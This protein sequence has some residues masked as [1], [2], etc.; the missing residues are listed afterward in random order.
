MGHRPLFLSNHKRFFRDFSST[1]NKGNNSSTNMDNNKYETFLVGVDGTSYGYL[2]LTKAFK[3][4][5]KNDKIIGYHIPL[6]SYQFAY[7]HLLFQPGIPLSSKQ[8][9]SYDNKRQEF[10]DKVTIKSKEI[11]D[12]YNK[13][14]DINFEMIIGDDS[15][16]VKQDLVDAV[17]D[18]KVNT[19]VLGCKGQTHSLKERI[20]RS[21]VDILGSVPDYCVH[22]ANCSV[23][24]VKPED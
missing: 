18:F 20:E 12:K 8:Q 22:N 15:I 21:V 11:N 10:V 5:K 9:E 24:V 7:E 19:L 16:A 2:A 3:F 13:N 14:N 4:A 6:D 1:T 17:D 23:I